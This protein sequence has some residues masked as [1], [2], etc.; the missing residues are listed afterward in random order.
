[1]P[2]KLTITCIVVVITFVVTLLVAYA[3]AEL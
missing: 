2:R 1:M 3:Q